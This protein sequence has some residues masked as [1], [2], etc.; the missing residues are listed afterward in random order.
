MRFSAATTAGRL[1][2]QRMASRARPLLDRIDVLINDRGGEGEAG[3]ISLAAFT[4]RIASALIA[5]VSQVLLARWMGSFEYGVYVLVWVTMVIVGNLSCLGFHTSVIRF[6]PE[7]RESGR[8]AELRGLLPASRVFVLVVSSLTAAAG[9]LGVWALSDAVASYYVLPFYLGLICLPMIALSD[10]L[11][12]IA[13]ANS[14]TVSALS[15]IYLLRPLLIL[16]FMALAL[17]VGYPPSAETAILAAIAATYATTLYQLLTTT[18]RIDR[19]LPAGPRITEFRL[20]I[21]VSLPIFLVEGFFFLLT[22]ADVLMVGFFLD[23]HDV[24]VYYAA[25]KVL[26]LVHFVY[27]AVKAGVAPQF[28][29]LMQ[30]GESKDLASFARMTVSWTFWPS[31]GLGLVLLAA[32][33][34][35]LSLFGPG[36]DE[37]YTL[38]FLLVPGVLARAAVGPAES[39]L[40][41][42]GYQNAC[43]AIYS[44]ALALNIGLN[45][46]LIPEF[47]IWGAALATAAAT[48]FEAGAL[49]LTVWRKHRISML[50]F[51]PQHSSER[52]A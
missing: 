27:F 36:F 44:A 21:T 4:I 6:I 40:T 45:V 29:Q 52:L 18:R 42:T 28:A 16:A 22:N 20:W 43:A 48:L 50:I 25:A 32:G 14:W 13:R 17:L 35:L 33:K 26:A 37:G 38:L 7:Y 3:R 31:L 23:P 9:A 8:L 10:T 39:L 47:G 19:R 11:Q 2:P 12:G 30:K 34:P 15:A 46:L 1:L 24:A 5:L 49:A 41:M 51:I